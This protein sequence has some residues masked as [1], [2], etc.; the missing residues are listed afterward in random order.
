M[1]AIYFIESK[2]IKYYKTDTFWSKLKDQLHAKQ[3]DDS[4][5]DQERFL[6]SLLYFPNKDDKS[7]EPQ[8]YDLVKTIEFYDNSIYGY[9][10]LDDNKNILNTYHLNLIQFDGEKF[11]TSDYKQT[12]RQEKINKILK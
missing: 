4:Q 12:L 11:I 5:H 1:I 2:G 3:H 7:K 8:F 10:T 6:E 9:Q